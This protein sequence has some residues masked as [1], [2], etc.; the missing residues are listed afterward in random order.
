MGALEDFMLRLL[1]VCAVVS[2]VFDEA[3]ATDNSARTTG[4]DQLKNKIYY[5]NLT[6]YIL[7]FNIAW[8]EGAA[9]FIAVFVVAFVGSYN[10][11]KKEQ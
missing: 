2:I 4:R 9:I 7:I 8:I 3:F 11:F 6:T 10:D 1:L 5:N